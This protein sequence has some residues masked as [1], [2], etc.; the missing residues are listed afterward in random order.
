MGKNRGIDEIYQ[1]IIILYIINS[2]KIKL[3][4][5]LLKELKMKDKT[6]NKTIEILLHNISYYFR[7]YDGDIDEC[8]IEEISSQIQKGYNQ[9][10]LCIS[11]PDD[12]DEIYY[13]WW[14]IDK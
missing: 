14:S 6:D 1:K 3:F 7:E 4:T 12:P 5:I 13:G 11:D 2:D 10:N 9:G 8:G